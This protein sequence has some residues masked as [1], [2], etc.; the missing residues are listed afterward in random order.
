L[1]RLL[2]AWHKAFGSNPTKIRE[3]VAEATTTMDTDELR[4]VAMEIAELRGEIN[5][6]RFGNWITRH[7]GRIVDGRRF[8]KDSGTTSVVQ[9]R[10][11]VV[12]SGMSGMT[13]TSRQTTESVTEE[14]TADEVMEGAL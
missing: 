3:V 11:K 8:E 4:S 9:W 7:A 5:N 10:V 12:Q 14:K 2:H 13:G 1:G 6:T